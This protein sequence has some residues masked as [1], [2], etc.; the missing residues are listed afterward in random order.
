[1]KKILNIT[2]PIITFFIG[3]IGT[4]LVC[5]L[6]LTGE[7]VVT[8][9][10]VNEVSITETNTIKDSVEKVYD[11]V[12]TVESYSYG[13]KKSFRCSLW[14]CMESYWIKDRRKIWLRFNK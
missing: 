12:V 4:Y 1:M 6:N 14:F 11:S 10:T 2:I 5:K 8:S 7:T 13:M 9:K 3:I